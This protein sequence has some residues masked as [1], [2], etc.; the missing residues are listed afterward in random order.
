MIKDVEQ[1]PGVRHLYRLSSSAMLELATV[2][3]VI[4]AIKL[5]INYVGTIV[6]R[7]TIV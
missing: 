5:E 6:C 7:L 4:F 1:C 2:L 3:A